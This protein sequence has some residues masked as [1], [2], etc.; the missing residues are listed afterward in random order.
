MSLIKRYD[1]LTICN[2]LVDIVYKATD[3][4]LAQFN[5]RKG[6]M[7]LVESE[8]QNIILSHFAGRDATVELGGSSLNAMRA[9]AMLKKKTVFAGMLAKDR[10]G[11]TVEKRME[12]LNIKADLH[13]TDKDSTGTCVVL[14]TEDGER[15]MNT[16]LGASR[17]YTKK[18]IP[19]EDLKNTKAF[20]ISGYQWD[21]KEQK[22]AIYE[23]LKLAKEAGCEISFDLADPFVVRN[24]KDEFAK[25]IKDYADIVFAN[26]E[27][28]H[29]LFGLFAEETA[30]KIASQGACAVIKLGAK[31]ALIQ[32]DKEIFRIGAVPTQVV[33][34]TG[35]GDMFAAGFLYGYLSNFGLEVAGN[36][37]AYL[38][39]DVISRFG[40]NLSEES[41]Q[42]ILRHYGSGRH[43]H[44]KQRSL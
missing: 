39:S 19:V 8:K 23:A 12:E 13:Y 38:A 32:K 33:D 7:N 15:T 6:H 44:E 2:A 31:G 1:V 29:L 35:A 21:T 20:H 27:E 43:P 34:T 4:E 9:L 30:E 22:E 25:V 37:A 42:F 17:L 5:L 24:H 41:V 28:A 10:Y 26:E 3:M 36:I 40:A 11:F 14:V 16:H 18:I